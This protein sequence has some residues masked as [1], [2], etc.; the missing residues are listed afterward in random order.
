[1]AMFEEPGFA[2]L[3]PRMSARELMPVPRLAAAVWL[4]N[5]R[6]FSKLWRGALLPTFADRF[7]CDVVLGLRDDL[8]RLLPDERAPPVRQRSLDSGR[9]SGPGRRRPRLERHPRD[10]LRHRRP[11]RGV[12]LRPRLLPVGDRDPAVRRAWWPV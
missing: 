9:G 10:R 12:D 6:V 1:M 8:Q 3:G 2:G 7:R 5:A 4:R 11:R